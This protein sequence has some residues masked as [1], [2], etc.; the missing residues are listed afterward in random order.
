MKSGQT[1]ESPLAAPSHPTGLSRR[2][3]FAKRVEKTLVS[4]SASED[5]EALEA[6][7]K[8]RAELFSELDEAELADYRALK[9]NESL[10]HRLRKKV[11]EWEKKQAA[12]APG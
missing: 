5:D 6:F 9:E 11:A 10:T 4:S 3:D 12:M 8:T 1:P 2:V 7:E